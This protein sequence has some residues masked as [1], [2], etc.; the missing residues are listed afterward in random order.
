MK[1]HLNSQVNSHIKNPN[2]TIDCLGVVL[3]GGLSSRMGQ[4]KA[5]LRR[6]NTSMLNFSKDL[7]INSGVNNVVVSGS[8]ELAQD[9]ALGLD[10][11]IIPDA[12]KNAG[13]VGGIYSILQ[14]YNPKALLILPVDLPLM[15]QQSL[16]KLRMAGELSQK[17]SYFDDHNIPLYLPNNA[18]LTLFLAK[19]F[20]GLNT[21]N[22]L[23]A[24]TSTKNAPSIKSMLL[25]VP[26]QSIKSTQTNT[27]FN[28]NTPQQWQ[29]A[30]KLFT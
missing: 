4:N 22:M 8:N 12:I 3:A 7:L 5:S 1:S 10:A 29:A 19:A 9:N 20:N 11:N 13:P 15:T 30:K 14:R 26:H 23:K 28:S 17:A 25:Q 2:Q 21:S 18:F 6:N 24:D 16:Q 27:L